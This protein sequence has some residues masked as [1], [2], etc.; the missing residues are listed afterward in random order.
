M[1][2]SHNWLKQN[3][4]YGKTQIK[5][6]I[7][8]VAQTITL[9]ELFDQY[10]NTYISVIE[11]E[12][13][14]QGLE[15]ED[16]VTNDNTEYVENIEEIDF[17]NKNVYVLDGNGQYIK[18]N[19]C[20]KHKRNDAEMLLIRTR[21]T[22]F[23]ETKN[24]GTIG[25]E[26]ILIVTS[27]HQLIMKSGTRKKVSSIKIGDHLK[28]ESQSSYQDMVVVEITEVD[29]EEYDDVYNISTNSGTF[30]NG[31]LTVVGY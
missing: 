4:Y 3:S 19:R 22:N 29:G 23:K 15:A 16:V 1:P 31:Y 14:S 27:D 30:A 24:E 2:Y 9:D 20:L 12:D 18:I 28:G 5:A 6:K 11:N 17:S 21:S 7:N 13:D 25:F 10:C 8:E 26:Q